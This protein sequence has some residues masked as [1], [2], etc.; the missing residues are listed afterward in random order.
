MVPDNT[1]RTRRMPS[2]VLRTGVACL[3]ISLLRL[4]PVVDAPKLMPF[5]ER[6]GFCRPP[7]RHYYGS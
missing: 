2:S 1:D 3:S 6:L 7:K 4:C 5:S